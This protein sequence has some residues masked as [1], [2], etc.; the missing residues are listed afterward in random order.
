[1]LITRKK[2]EEAAAGDVILADVILVAVT[3]LA[4]VQE[5]TLEEGAFLPTVGAVNRA[6][7]AA[8]H[9]LTPTHT[10]SATPAVPQAAREHLPL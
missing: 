1:M 7:E 5:A 9:A 2:E 10:Q 3:I 4:D 6:K 8:A